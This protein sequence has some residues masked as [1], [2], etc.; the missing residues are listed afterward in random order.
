MPITND[1]HQTAVRDGLQTLKL[2]RSV[3]KSH[4]VHAAIELDSLA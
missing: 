3:R 1:Y 4:V 2:N